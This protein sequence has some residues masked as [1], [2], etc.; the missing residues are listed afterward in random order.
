MSQVYI[1]RIMCVRP[2]RGTN[3]SLTLAAESFGQ[4]FL[5]VAGGA[6]W[7]AGHTV[8]T[9]NVIL[10]TKAGVVAGVSGA[11][12]TFIGAGTWLSGQIDSDRAPDD[13][14]VRVGGQ[15]VWPEGASQEVTGGETVPVRIPLAANGLTVELRERDTWSPDDSLGSTTFDWCDLPSGPHSF[16]VD[17]SYEDSA[18]LIEV[19]VE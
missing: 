2:A 4:L 9:G 15:K 19:M 12:G 17:S 8:K 1:S 7:V 13:L 6:A 5:T 18:Y 10:A 14:Y 16:P 11:I 3:P